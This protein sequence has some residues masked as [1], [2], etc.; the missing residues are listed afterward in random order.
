MLLKRLTGVG[1]LLRGDI[2]LDVPIAKRLE[3]WRRGF[4][5]RAYFLYELDKNDIAAYLPDSALKKLA[6][7]NGNVGESIFRNKLM[8]E[9]FFR[10]RLPVVP[11]LGWQSRGQTFTAEGELVS[12]DALARWLEASPSGLILKP[13][14]GSEGSG[15][16]HLKRAG[17]HLSLNGAPTDLADLAARL[18][19]CSDL[20]IS[21]FVMQ[22]AYAEAIFPGV[23]STLRVITMQHVPGE[24]FVAA[25]SHRLATRASAPTDNASRGALAARFDI[26][27]GR[28]GR[29]A[30]M[31]MQVGSRAVWCSHHPDTNAHI[32][33]VYVP[34]WP[35]VRDHL[36]GV[37]ARLP[38]LRYVGWDIAITDDGYRVIEGNSGASLYIQ[39]VRPFLEDARTREFLEA[40]GAWSPPAR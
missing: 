40:V 19:R 16:L 28:L 8:F 33:G 15:V 20:L 17:E 11:V 29:A 22:A 3:L 38:F 26:E 27:T 7:L 23:V 12:P 31:P 24:P 35:E 30:A 39:M 18:A 37:V 9:R 36:L 25:V 21:P 32:E 4:G 34:H 5:S 2:P 10:E 1:Q 14:A 6:K 13:L